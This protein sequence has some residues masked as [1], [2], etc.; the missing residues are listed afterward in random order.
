LVA[1]HDNMRA[2]LAWGL[3][4]AADGSIPAESEPAA[5]RPIAPTPAP[6][7]QPA[8]LAPRLAA[9][10]HWFWFLHG[11]WAEG[12]GWLE[13][14]L[15]RPW[16]AA[17]TARR[18][19][20]LTAL[21]VLAFA[22]SDGTA[23]RDR[24]DESIAVAREADDRRNLAYALL[25]RAW[26]ALIAGDFAAMASF[27]AESLACFRDLDDPWGVTV[28]LCSLGLARSEIDA[29]PAAANALLDESL[30]RARALG[31]R[32][33]IARAEICLGELARAQGD[34]A[35]AAALYEESLVY[36]RQLGRPKQA[37]HV[38]YNLGQIAVERGDGQR[39]AALFAEALEL[40]SQRGERRGLVLCLAGVAA[41][42]ALQG[43]ADRAARYFGAM[44]ALMEAA[45]VALEPLDRASYQRHRAAVRTK[46]GDSAFSIAHALGQSPL[47]E[48]AAAEALAFAREA[49]TAAP[50]P[51]PTPFGLSPRELEVLRLLTEGRTD[52]EI[53][54]S[55]SVSERTVHRH[56]T[57]VL[58]KLRVE[59]RTAAA[60]LAVRRGLA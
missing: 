35:R 4:F 56:V 39:A 58:S 10:L 44:E 54:A 13:R 29:D 19:H 36:L 31:D 49:A 60:T 51:G 3:D 40:A 43:Q 45:G 47:P 15:D 20:T 33:S 9:A 8:M 32:W 12:R 53:A 25:C 55:L 38:L 37:G 26:P 14:A 48:Q 41:V 42:A 57:A 28:A 24:L 27:A 22:Q 30:T 16:P 50:S 34:L 18:A 17:S 5:T 21:G 46:L 59:T 2:A 11:H 1:E 52:R 6:A 7:P 23:A